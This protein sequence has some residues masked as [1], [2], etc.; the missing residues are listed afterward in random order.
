MSF[1][2]CSEASDSVS[3]TAWSSC[4]LAVMNREPGATFGGFPALFRVRKQPLA[5]AGIHSRPV[6]ARRM[7][8]G[9]H[10]RRACP[11][12]QELSA[13]LSNPH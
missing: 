4:I 3:H 7:G 5:A 2:F 10:C 6:V 1:F 13:I 8:R 9:Q 12:R 11:L